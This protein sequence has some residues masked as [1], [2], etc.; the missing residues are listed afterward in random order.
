MAKNFFS[1]TS[2]RLKDGS[3]VDA[4]EHLKGKIVV[5]YFSAS[6]CGPCRQFT[7]IMKELYQQIAETNQPIEVILLSRDYMRFQLDEY[8][9]QHGC[10]WGVVPLRDPIIEKCLNAYNVTALPSCR[11]VD[12]GKKEEEKGKEGGEGE[13][14][15]EA[16]SSTKHTCYCYLTADEEAAK[17]RV[18]VTM[19]TRKK[20]T[21]L[22]LVLFYWM[23]GWVVSLECYDSSYPVPHRRTECGPDMMCYSEY[24]A[25]NRSGA[26]RQYYDR[27]CVHE[28]H[29]L[30]RGI[31]ESCP[32]LGQLD[33]KMQPHEAL[34]TRLEH[35]FGVKIVYTAGVNW[36]Q[37][38][39]VGLELDE[40]KERD[41]R[42]ILLDVDEEMAATVLCAGYHRGMYGD[43][44]VW[45][46]PGYHSDKWL[47]I[48][49]DNCT[50][51][52]LIE[53]ARNHFSVEF[54]LSRR[55]VDTKIVGNTR[56]GDVWNEVSQLDPNNTWRGYL[57]DG[58]WTLAIALSHSMGE[59]AEFSHHKM[60]EAIDNSSFQG[61]TGK[62]KFANNERLGL[63]DIMQWSDGSYRPFAV[64]D[65]AEDEFKIIDSSITGWSPPLDSTITER[66]REHISS[67]L[68]LAMSLLALIGIFLALIFLLINFRYRNH[69]FIK[70]S[71]PNLNNIIIAGSICTFAS[72]ILLGLDTRIVN[73]DVFVWLCYVKTWTLCI[74]FT[75]AFGAMF[76]K[77][78]RVHSIFTNIR[79][80]RKAIKDSK[81][82]L[83]LG[84]LLFI[85]ICVLVTWAF[86]SP[87]SYTVTE[88]P[89]IPEDNIVIIPEVEKCYSRNS[90]VFQAVLYAV[91][92]IL[93]ILGCFLAWETRHVNVPALNDSK[94]IGTS[95]YCVVVMSVLGLSTSVIL[96]E[97]VNEMFSLASFFVIFST[98]LTLCLVFVPKVIE[99]ARNPVGNEPRAYRRG[100]M[101]S[102]VAKTS[103]PISP[104]PRSESSG[105]LL[106]KAE[107]ENKLRRRYLHQKSTQLWD[108]VEKLRARGD[109]QFLQQGQ[110]PAQAELNYLNKARWIEMY[111]V[112][113]H[114]VEGRDGNTY[115]LGL[116]PQGMLVFDGPQKIGLF[117]WER[118]QKLDFKNKKITLGG[119]R[120]C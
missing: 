85:D 113:M 54:A 12:E 119:G 48:T 14:E 58:L 33:H 35:G 37:I 18:L 84:V 74:G 79:M 68:F 118:L 34:T 72:V 61:L 75:L 110:T 32:T 53:A 45:I 70:M 11:V 22:Q 38:E 15:G 6:W 117:L 115:R 3:M 102:V 7:P 99:L 98:T 92:G 8:Y 88:F 49:H 44:Y 97:R 64:Y 96:Q 40:L 104:Q 36:E 103:Q 112:D 71:S 42:I 1:G 5:L 41:V 51:E 59:N 29:C 19:E 114:T 55:D 81:L 26:I 93:M 43:N 80:D 91:K 82:L 2:L 116:T 94:Y 78:W 86:I 67:L 108:L 24:Y 109:T 69:R 28:S 10:S 120:G 76:S 16:V 39:T 30:Y 66:R 100:L 23:T 4:G 31:D 106:G 90:G 77:T 65:G 95:V 107:S 46:L 60:I 21:I 27:F 17:F 9:E 73:L 57:Y 62:V 89:H 63:V 13:E 25:V 56:A 50:T 101:K 83:I 47:N 20:D 52:Q 87:F 111:G 105:D